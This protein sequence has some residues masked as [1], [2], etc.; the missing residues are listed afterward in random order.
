MIAFP[1]GLKCHNDLWKVKMIYWSSGL[2]LGDCGET[3]KVEKRIV[4]LSYYWG[5]MS[6]HFISVC[7]PWFGIADGKKVV[8]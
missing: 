5:E 4:N 8:W 6:K 3:L 7:Q 2:S 1:W